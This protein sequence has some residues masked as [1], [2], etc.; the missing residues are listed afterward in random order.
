MSELL[1]RIETKLRAAFDPVELRV[2]D[3]SHLHAGHGGAA[4]HAAEFGAS[5]PS[6]I[7]IALEAAA[8]ADLSRLA[9]HRAVMDAI[10]EEVPR[11]HAIRMT[12][13]APS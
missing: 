5:E 8:L 3:E 4:E 10:S 12:L 1:H 2:E 7:H 9:R 11:L 13:D 6:H